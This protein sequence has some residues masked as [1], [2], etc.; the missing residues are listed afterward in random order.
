[1]AEHHSETGDLP[2]V[3]VRTMGPDTE[4]VQEEREMTV[5]ELIQKLQGCDQSA[6]VQVDVTI[7]KALHTAW[8]TDFDGDPNAPIIVTDAELE[9]W[10]IAD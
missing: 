2:Q 10:C 9:P 6:R 5:A 1:M 3:Q 7:G 8:I 4:T